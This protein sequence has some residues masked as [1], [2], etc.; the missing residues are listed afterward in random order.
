MQRPRNVRSW[1][2][3]FLIILI[4]LI[5]A[6]A[7]GGAAG[8]YAGY[9]EGY[10]SALPVAPLE[11]YLLNAARRV[12]P[13]V[14][15]IVNQT[16]PFAGPGVTTTTAVESGSGLIFDPGGYIITNNHVIQRAQKLQVTLSDGRKVEGIVVGADSMADI[17]IVKVN[18]PVPAAVPLADSS[19]L[20]PGQ[21]VMVIGS[22]F[23]EFRETLAMG[24]ISGLNRRVGGMQGLIQTD[25]A[26]NAGNSGGPLVTMRGEVVGINTM[27]LRSTPDGRILE[28]MG[29][30]IP[31]NQVREFISKWQ[32]MKLQGNQ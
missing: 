14:V 1:F 25:A 27:V 11:T 28:G 4:G 32:F 21:I 23:E 20:E 30:A 12:R 17:A 15:M 2:V 29:F 26:I 13:A 31:S 8:H 3:Q 10:R 22:P 18:E 24:V 5:G 9:L 19:G 6:A 16:Q 7:V